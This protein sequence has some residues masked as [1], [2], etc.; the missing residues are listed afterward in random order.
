LVGADAVEEF[1]AARLGLEPL[2]KRFTE[3]HLAN[4]L[5]GRRAPIKSLLLDQRL[6][7]GV[8]NIYADEALFRA[9]IH[10]LRPAGRLTKQQLASLRR[11]LIDA[12]CAGIHAKGASIDD[13]RHV[14]GLR[15]GFQDE[16]LVHDRAGEPCPRC[17]REVVRI[18]VAGRGTYVCEH[19]Q[20]R[21]R[22]TSARRKAPA[23]RARS[24]ATAA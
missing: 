16:F 23:L 14:D 12:L 5:R 11:G 24:R 7:A 17:G 22:R 6:I 1:F 8:G 13:F 2:D 10:P 9:G 4:V 18:V 3:D 21:P 15:G 19:D 20:P